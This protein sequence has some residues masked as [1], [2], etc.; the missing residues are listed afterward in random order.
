MTWIGRSARSNADCMSGQP[1]RVMC[2]LLGVSHSGFYG[3]FGR[4]RSKRAQENSRLIRMVRES[5]ELSD[6]TYGSPRVWRD[7]RAA[8]EGCSVNR[9]ARLMKRVGL[10]AR[11]RRR[12]PGNTCTSAAHG[13]APNHLQR[14]FEADAPNQKWVADFTY[15]TPSQRSP[16]VWG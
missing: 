11:Q 16:P 7:L 6:K 5:F 9:V 14:Q 8:G 13:V 4:A 10:Q 1:T 12:M 3:W 15:S 2:R